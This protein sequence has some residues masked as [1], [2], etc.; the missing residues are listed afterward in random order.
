MERRAQDWLR[1]R[2]GGG[3]RTRPR[4]SHSQ[5]VTKG[6]TGER[7]ESVRGSQTTDDLD[8]ETLNRTPPSS[9]S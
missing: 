3:P 6:L 7:R 2:H 4:A 8:G 9:H 5:R 1:E